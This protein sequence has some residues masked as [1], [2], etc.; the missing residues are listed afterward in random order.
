MARDNCKLKELPQ[1]FVKLD[2]IEKI[3]LSVLHETR[4]M[5]ESINSITSTISS[6]QCKM[7]KHMFYKEI[8]LF[9]VIQ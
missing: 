6:A 8:W 2:K 4:T 1:L 9:I 7:V 3:Y 5:V